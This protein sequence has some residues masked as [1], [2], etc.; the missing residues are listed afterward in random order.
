VERNAQN[1]KRTMI[2]YFG[3]LDPSGWEMLPPLLTTLQDEMGLG[4]LVAGR[5]CALTPAQVEANKLPRNPD[6]LKETDTRA[7]K[8]MARF[9]DLAVELDALPPATLEALV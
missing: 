4:D 7:K 6:A 9:G 2:L 1:G 3:D 5:R 8:Y